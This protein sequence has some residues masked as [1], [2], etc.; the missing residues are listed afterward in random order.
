[1]AG[2][3]ELAAGRGLVDRDRAA[4]TQGIFEAWSP[5]RA[6]LTVRIGTSRLGLREPGRHRASLVGEEEV[7]WL[8]STA[9]SFVHG[10]VRVIAAMKSSGLEPPTAMIG[11]RRR[12][13]GPVKWRA[14]E[15][16]GVV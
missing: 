5:D 16:G 10:K 13:I 15:M 2:D 14:A 4:R 3:D 12:S 9:A 11:R 6:R 1:M 7:L 8:I